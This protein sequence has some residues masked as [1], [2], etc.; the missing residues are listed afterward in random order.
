MFWIRSGYSHPVRR[1]QLENACLAGTAKSNERFFILCYFSI[2][3]SHVTCYKAEDVTNENTSSLMFLAFITRVAFQIPPY[4]SFSSYYFSWFSS[5]WLY[6]CNFPDLGDGGYDGYVLHL[7]LMQVRRKS[8]SSHYVVGKHMFCK[9]NVIV[10]WNCGIY[11]LIAL[12]NEIASQWNFTY[13]KYYYSLQRDTYS[14]R[15]Q[16]SGFYVMFH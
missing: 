7:R 9:M 14:F 11:F 16:S 5:L 6:S 10:V 12:I 1:S 2:L 3:S 15:N 8:L 13:S 4:Y